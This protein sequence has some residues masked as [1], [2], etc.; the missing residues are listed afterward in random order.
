ML[1]Y[2]LDISRYGPFAPQCLRQRTNELQFDLVTPYEFYTLEGGRVMLTFRVPNSRRGEPTIFK[3]QIKP[4]L[5]TV[6]I[7][8]T[9][10][11]NTPTCLLVNN[12]QIRVESER[13]WLTTDSLPIEAF[14]IES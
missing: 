11:I 10:D 13:Q 14:I 4:S 1:E 8:I 5:S 6:V 9:L 12:Q 3:Q 2:L 7:G